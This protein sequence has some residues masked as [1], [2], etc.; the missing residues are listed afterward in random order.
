MHCWSGRRDQEHA[1]DG[2]SDAIAI[3]SGAGFACAARSDGRVLCWGTT[4]WGV[5]GNG[6]T[7][8]ATGPTFIHGLP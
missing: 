7:S 2:V 4:A 6:V 8:T 5:L 1:I 3:A